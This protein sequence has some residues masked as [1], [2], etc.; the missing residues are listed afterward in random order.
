[1]RETKLRAVIEYPIKTMNISM[2]KSVYQVDTGPIA[3]PELEKRYDPPI[4]ALRLAFVAFNTPDFADFVVEQPTPVI[5]DGQEH[6][7]SLPLLQAIQSARKKSIVRRI[8]AR[9]ILERTA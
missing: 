3:L 6:G 2:D 7:A 1:M 9:M 4:D 8:A 5:Q